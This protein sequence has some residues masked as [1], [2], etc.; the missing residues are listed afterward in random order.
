MNMEEN[1]N[2]GISAPV[3]WGLIIVGI[4][5]L[6]I[7]LSNT[8][9]RWDLTKEKRYSLSSLSKETVE[10]LGG[11]L[12]VTSYL[13]GEFPV[14]I[15]RFQAA[16]NT[17]LIELDQYASE[18]VYIE[19]IDPSADFTGR[20]SLRKYGFQ[21]V[22]I[23]VLDAGERIE[24][25]L[26]AVVKLGYQDREGFW[27]ETYLDLLENCLLPNGQINLEKA[28]ADLE[29]QL[30]SRIR[31]LKEEEPVTVAVLQ[32]Q[33]EYELDEL[34]PDLFR[35]LATNYNFLFGEII[36]GQGLDE[37]IDVLL[38]LQ[39]TQPFSER[40]KYELDQYLMRGGSIIWVMDYQ[41]VD[42]AVFENRSTVTEVYNLN[43]DDLFFNYGIKLNANLLQDL[44]M[45]RIEFLEETQEGP[46]FSARPWP[47]YVRIRPELELPVTRNVER[48]LIRY[49]G[50]I[51]TFPQPG[52]SKEVF[53]KSTP[54]SR[55]LANTQFI[56]LGQ[57]MANLE[58][59]ELFQQ[60][61]GFITGTL[62]T[63]QLASA[64][65]GRKLPA[66]SIPATRP[67]LPNSQP[68]RPAQMA[69]IS[70]G[71]FVMGL[72]FRGRRQPYLPYDNRTLLLNL[73][74]YLVGDESLSRIRAKEVAVRPLD[75][76]KIK[77][78]ATLIRTVNLVLPILLILLF[79]GIRYF[80]RKR[81]YT[82]SL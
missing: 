80:W 82:R 62:L 44:N 2:K 78:S 21:P 5:L 34:P 33:G 45:E 51:D 69:L 58:Q 66:D 59:P 47:F 49:A 24:K 4:F 48:T 29:Y 68:D 57:V 72:D 10:E 61:E 77:N 22:K 25:D 18:R 28:E 1:T 52:V 14:Q 41:K 11:P 70:D 6:N 53:L 46:K 17:T 37:Q 7:F 43:L 79:G 35:G 63:G 38:I 19:K 30:V 23:E 42:L 54:R 60:S 32:G 75:T 55:A 27:R 56:D 36:P 73:I 81:K 13:E 40:E 39:P 8:F 64:F 67:F 76:D 20:D 26:Y 12:Y 31:R 16:V 15:G 71:E 9:I 65:V 50:T 74:D 3:R